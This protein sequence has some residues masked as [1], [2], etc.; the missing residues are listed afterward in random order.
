[1]AH[2][3]I[4]LNMLYQGII[5]LSGDGTFYRHFVIRRPGGVPPIFIP[6]APRPFGSIANNT[7]YVELSLFRRRDGVAHTFDTLAHRVVWMFFYGPIPEN[8]GI[9][10]IDGIKHHNAIGNLEV[11]TPKQNMQHAMMVTG[12]FN[13]RKENNPNAKLTS[14]EVK[15]IR[16]LYSSGVKL[17]ELAKKFTVVSKTQLCRIVHGLSWQE[18]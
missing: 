9:N 4:F 14:H 5:D 2:E 10:H 15:R 3:S 16:E 13:P 17:H 7:D 1:M 12:T 8:M 6:V 18:L 11:V